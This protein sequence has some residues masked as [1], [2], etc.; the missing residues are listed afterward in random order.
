MYSLIFGQNIYGD[1]KY[2]LGGGH[3]YQK[4]IILKDTAEIKNRA[5][6]EI[7]LDTFSILYENE[8]KIY[9]MLEDSTAM[10]LNSDIIIGT[11]SIKNSK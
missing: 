3:P 11:I 8:K 9:L 7:N 2:E 6:K 10:S 4:Q 1:I 5:I